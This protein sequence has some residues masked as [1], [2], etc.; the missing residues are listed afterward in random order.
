MLGEPRIAAQHP[1]AFLIEIPAWSKLDHPLI[2]RKLTFVVRDG[3]R[4]VEQD[5]PIE[6]HRQMPRQEPMQ[7]Q[8]GD[9]K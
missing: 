9:A 2:G 5:M 1:A 4:V 3:V 6:D 7:S 8:K